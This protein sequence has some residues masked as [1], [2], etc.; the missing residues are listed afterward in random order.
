MTPTIH[1]FTQTSDVSYDRHYYTLHLTG[2]GTSSW[3]NYEELR[4]HWMLN[5][6][7]G[8]EHIEVMDPKPAKSRTK[9][10][11]F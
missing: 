7:W 10:K 8:M 2:G 11:G 9:A 5:Q 4:N 1:T 3:E 6:G